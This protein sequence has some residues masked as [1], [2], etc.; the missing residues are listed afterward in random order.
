[1]Q[2]TKQRGMLYFSV[3]K[4]F[5]F[6]LWRIVFQMELNFYWLNLQLLA[7]TLRFLVATK[8]HCEYITC[9]T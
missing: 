1:M 6:K 4:E 9:L 2:K 3:A 7:M 8:C 5:S